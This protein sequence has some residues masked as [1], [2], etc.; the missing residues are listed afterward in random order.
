LWIVASLW[1]SYTAA[2]ILKWYWWRF[3]GFGYF[4]GMF[5]GI[6]TSLILTLLD[7]LALIPFLDN[8]PLPNNPSMN[9][10]PIIFAVSIIACVVG[11]LKTKPE[12][13][14]VLIKF[15]R[16]VKP[17]GFWKPVMKKVLATDPGFIPNKN[18]KRDMF[19]IFIGI[20]WQ[21][22]LMATPIF[23]VIREYP[24]L[25]TALIVLAVTSTILKLNWWNKLES[26][27]G[28]HTIEL[29]AKV[30]EHKPVLAAE[31]K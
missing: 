1:G 3:N 14:E 21:V 25:I 17:W 2:N 13:D 18:F 9:S 4:W 11:T 5:S 24:S 16:T 22:T 23:L 7:K 28:E 6:I 12:S 8:F 20:I 26:S 27:Y 29:P 15:Y 30:S 10:F 19:N 31:Q